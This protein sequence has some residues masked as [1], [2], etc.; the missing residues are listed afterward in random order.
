[1]T[2]REKAARY[3]RIVSY[4]EKCIENY[5]TSNPSQYDFRGKILKSY[6]DGTNKAYKTIL[7]KLKEN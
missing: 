3:D 6:N 5:K 4:L 7:S 2:E 1:M